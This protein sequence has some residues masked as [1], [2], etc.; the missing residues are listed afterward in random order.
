MIDSHEKEHGVVRKPLRAFRRLP[1]AASIAFAALGATAAA[2]MPGGGQNVCVRLESQLAAID[3]GTAD[4]ARQEQI[5][6]Y[7]DAA[8]KQQAELDRTVAQSRRNG[9]ENSGFFFFG[10]QSAQCGPLTRQIQQMRGNLDRILSDLERLRAGS[11]GGDPNQR[12]MVLAALAQNDCGPQYRAAAQA[13]QPRGFFDSLFGGSNNSAGYGGQQPLDNMAPAG[14]FRTVCVRT[15]D[16]FYWP[17]SYATVP[18]R[19]A[20]DERTCQNMCPATEVSL[21]SHRNPGEDMAQAVSVSGRPYSQLPAA[22]SYRK[23]F[24]PA[25]TCKKPGESWADALKNSSDQT[26]ER[27]DIVV[28]EE[29]AKQLAQPPRAAGQRQQQPARKGAPQAVAQPMAQPAAASSQ[30]AQPAPPP[31][32]GPVRTVG[33]RFLP[34]Q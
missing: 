9:C 16:G 24:N 15:C 28:T 3:R 22:F 32:T 23:E 29:R 17:I 12:R 31:P 6:R 11:G 7:E 21:Y 26:V 8:Q 1:L 5:R 33:P 27:G 20:D 13:A 4:P 2:Q 10:G 19:F 18:S 30:D 25:C 14:T 34:A